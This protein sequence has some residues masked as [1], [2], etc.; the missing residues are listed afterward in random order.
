MAMKKADN[1]FT[2]KKEGEGLVNK[3]VSMPKYAKRRGESTAEQWEGVSHSSLMW[4]EALGKMVREDVT[5]GT[6]PRGHLGKEAA[7]GGH[8]VCKGP[9]V[10]AC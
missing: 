8:S 1:V 9:E 6:G 2:C 5:G 10:G 7:G 3:V 4:D